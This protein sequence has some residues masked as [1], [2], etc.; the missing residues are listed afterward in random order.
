[1][2]KINVNLYGGKSIFKGV[3]EMPLEAEITY[4]D[5][6]EKCS[7]YKNRTCFSAGRWKVNCKFG[8]KEIIK[9][10]TSR[11]T[12]YYD[13]QRTY[14]NDEKYNLLK[15][16]SQTIGIIDGIVILNLRYIKIIE[17][18]KVEEDVC[19]GKDDLVYIPLN[20]FNNNIIKQICDIKPRTLFDDGYIRTYHEKI[21]PRFLYE[22]K[23]DFK[24]IYDNFINEYPEYNKKFNFVGRK[25]YINSLRDGLEINSKTNKWKIS[26]G[27]IICEKWHDI[28]PF[29]AR[30]GEV[31]IEITDD[32]I[33]EI[34]NNEQV[35][36]NTKFAD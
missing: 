7:F 1:M 6:C 23:S 20:K 10:Y 16:P 17:D 4:C 3:K 22:L 35:D 9:G 12:K 26:K 30:Y 29:D 5:K 11:A 32:L 27:Y 15:E 33:C 2:N 31:K 28:Y 19:F 13:F 21:I 36:E 25:A 14:K 24:D 8:E 34:T 18:I